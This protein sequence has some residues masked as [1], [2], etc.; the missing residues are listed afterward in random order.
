MTRQERIVQALAIPGNLFLVITLPELRRQRISYLALYALQRTVEKA[1]DGSGDCCS[2]KWLR[3]ET[4]LRDY[5]SSRA[6]DLLAQG[7]LIT[8]S[9]DP[10]D[11]RVRELVSTPKGRQ[12]LR[13]ILDEAGRRLWEGIETAGRIRRVKEVTDHLRQANDILRKDFPLSFFDKDLFLKEPAT[14]KRK[15]A[16]ALVQ[17]APGCGHHLMA[18][19]VGS[20]A[21]SLLP[22][23]IRAERADDF[24]KMP[25]P[26]YG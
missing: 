15:N 17:P 5:E 20:G 3:R 9:S 4:G 8:V 2:E 19:G 10:T 23:R 18:E 13:R 25:M 6:C 7:E 16:L 26:L 14:R 12:V 1:D 11:R 24:G 21:L 22:G